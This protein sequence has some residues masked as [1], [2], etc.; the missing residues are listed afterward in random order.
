MLSMPTRCGAPLRASFNPGKL[1][2]LSLWLEASSA[3]C[4]SDAGA[5]VPCNDGDSVRVWK[6][7][8]V[9]AVQF[10]QA[11]S[12]ARPTFRTSGGKSW[13]QFDGVDDLL[14]AS[15]YPALDGKSQCCV[16]ASVL[17]GASQSNG[18]PTFIS[19]GSGTSTATF[20]IMRFNAG[21]GETFIGGQS[22]NTVVADGSLIANTKY[23]MGCRYNGANHRTWLANAQSNT[24]ARTAAMPTTTGALRLGSDAGASTRVFTGRIYGLVVYSTDVLDADYTKLAAYMD[25]L[26]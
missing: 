1:S 13:V 21:T 14:D 23:V 6:S 4:F 8:D 5:S 19:L 25:G 3:Y 24:A 7:R 20:C 12:S 26:Q 10:S 16:V 2:N 15:D 9:N 18:L 22:T 17:T 11:T